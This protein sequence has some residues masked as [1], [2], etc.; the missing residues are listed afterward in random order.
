MRVLSATAGL[1]V[2]LAVFFRRGWPLRTLAFAFAPVAL[3]IAAFAVGLHLNA[4]CVVALYGLP[5]SDE[6]SGHDRVGR[7]NHFQGGGDIY[8]R[9]ETGAHEVHGAI[10]AK[11][12]SIGADQS[13]LGYPM[14][15]EAPPSGRF[16]HLQSGSA[17]RLRR[18]ARRRIAAAPARSAAAGRARACGRD[19]R[20]DREVRW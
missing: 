18:A 1:P 15:D 8:W 7:F 4:V 3:V 11:Y 13:P 16:N 20:R 10:N 14:T 9:P 2:G 17:G 6:T 5:L 19:R 12:Q